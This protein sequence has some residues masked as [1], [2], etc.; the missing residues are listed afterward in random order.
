MSEKSLIVWWVEVDWDLQL[1]CLSVELIQLRHLR[2]RREKFWKLPFGAHCFR[3]Y[4]YLVLQLLQ[5]LTGTCRLDIHFLNFKAIVKS[6]NVNRPSKPS[7]SEPE[8]VVTVS[9]V[10]SWVSTASFLV[11]EVVESVWMGFYFQQIIFLEKK[12]KSNTLTLTLRV[13][14]MLIVEF[15]FSLLTLG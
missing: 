7:L 1:W 6:F 15:L 3:H 11:L 4:F 8:E 5:S 10:G 2:L 9:F 13:D 12:E 14:L